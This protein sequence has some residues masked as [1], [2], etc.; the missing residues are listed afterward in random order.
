MSALLRPYLSIIVPAY[1]EEKT[2]SSTLL[3]LDR[4]L[5]SMR[6]PYEIICV[7]DGIVDKTYERAKK[8]SAPNIRVLSYQVNRGK[9]HS[10]RYGLARAKGLVT[11]FMD[12]NGI[13]PQSVQMVYQ[14][15]LWYN[16]DIIVGSKRHPVSKVKY[17]FQRRVI[18]WIYQKLVKLLFGLDIKDTQVGLKLFKREVLVKV[19]PR[20]LVKEFAFDIEILAVANYLGF[21]KIYEAPV[22]LELS[23]QKEISSIYSQG[24][25]RTVLMMLKDSLA[26]FYRMKVMRYYDDS[27]SDNWRRNPDLEFWQ[28]S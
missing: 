16:S 22:E 3:K 11:G 6:F 1:K 7:V 27:N 20:L 23:A 18:S 24:F 15:H 25:W 2:I 17:T 8:V 10:V 21:K 5:K 12:A 4:V 13:N 19:L 9:G 28:P 26:V 14:H